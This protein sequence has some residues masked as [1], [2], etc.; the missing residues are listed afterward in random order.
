[1][2]CIVFVN[3]EYWGIQTIKNLLNLHYLVSKYHINRYDAAVISGGGV[4]DDGVPG[5]EQHYLN[6]IG[7]IQYANIA[8]QQNYDYVNTQLDLQS[9]TDFECSEIWLGNGDWPNNNTKMWRFKRSYDAGA[10]NELDGRW[11][12][13]MYDLDAAFG[14]DCN[15]ITASFNTLSNAFDSTF[16]S[17]TLV[18]RTLINNAS[19]KNYFINRFADLLNTTFLPS[20]VRG[21]MNALDNELTPSM[22]EHVSRW[23]YPSVSTTLQARALETP[24]LTKWNTINSSLYNYAGLRPYK[25]RR[26]IL[27]YFGLADTVK[28]TLN[29]SD[30]SAGKIKMNT[31]YID[32]F[33]QGINAAPY[34]WTGTYFNGNAVSIEAI[35]NPGFRFLNWNDPSKTQNPLTTNVT[36]DTSVTAVFA[37]DTGFN[38]IHYLYINE[39]MSRND[40]YL[41]DDYDEFD[42]WIEL[43]NP[44]NFAVDVA[45]CYVSDDASQKNKYRIGE[46]N[47][48]TVI[49]ARGFIL[50]WADN[51]PEQGVT[52]TNFKLRASGG[53][54]WLTL[55]DGRTVVDSVIY[56]SQITDHSWGRAM[57]GDSAWIDWNKPTPRS[58]NILLPDTHLP[59]ALLYPNPAYNTQYIY[60]TVPVDAVISDALG[61]RI[62]E[63]H[64]AS[65]FDV[66]L[67]AKG[68]YFFHAESGEIIKFVK[69]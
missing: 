36:A 42:D 61:N 67:L 3:G 46:G 38:S 39:L 17:S 14:G 50:L 4:L 1:Q 59:E 25:V 48:S 37:P 20:R 2:H 63:L 31:I 54:I 27:N 19:Y 52:H 33:T 56:P 28:I 68:V 45:N 43:Y 47:H 44:N 11:H 26:H 41:H 7:F 57:D 18:L 53:G 55:P 66:T 65:R 23:R 8:T 64:Q 24:S 62:A 35:A 69:L 10:T 29:V 30:T 34:P 15:T 49:P 22:M 13:M 9:F 6:V 32:R 21:I 51:S 58:S 60:F 40:Q 12:W 16:G 5:D